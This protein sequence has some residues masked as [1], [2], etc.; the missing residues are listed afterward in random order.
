MGKSKGGKGGNAHS[1]SKSDLDSPAKKRHHPGST[2]H[3]T[4]F[5]SA[6]PL[7]QNGLVPRPDNPNNLSAPIADPNP[8]QHATPKVS[9]ME[10]FPQLTPAPAIAHNTSQH[11][12]LIPLSDTASPTAHDSVVS[13]ALGMMDGG[14]GTEGGLNP[15]GVEP[16]SQHLPLPPHHLTTNLLQTITAPMTKKT[17]MTITMTT[18]IQT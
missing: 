3:L 5:H 15:T 14:N 18:M 16:T 17:T 11:A 13:N 1:P 7:V 9:S 4:E 2:S 12:S 6:S 8:Q 10:S